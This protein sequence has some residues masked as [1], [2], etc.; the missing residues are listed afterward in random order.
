MQ[1]RAQ[2]HGA[3]Q[4]SAEAPEPSVRPN[5]RRRRE[6]V[7]RSVLGLEGQIAALE[8]KDVL[9]DLIG[10]QSYVLARCWNPCV[11]ISK[12]I[13]M[14]SWIPLSRMRMLHENRKF[15]LNTRGR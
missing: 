1:T 14:K 9:A 6:M 3:R 7:H 13:T 4:P 8:G 15:W 11:V 2:M 5:Y 12:R 10:K